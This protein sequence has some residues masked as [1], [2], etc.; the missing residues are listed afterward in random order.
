[1]QAC[2]L[3]SGKPIKASDAD[4]CGL[5]PGELAARYATLQVL[6]VLLDEQDLTAEGRPLCNFA[7]RKRPGAVPGAGGSGVVQVCGSSGSGDGSVGRDAACSAAAPSSTGLMSSRVP[8]AGEMS[9]D[10]AW[11]ATSFDT[12]NLSEALPPTAERAELG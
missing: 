7:A 10:D 4:A 3:K 5:V 9:S 11:C 2:S 6:D 8:P 12:R 1:M